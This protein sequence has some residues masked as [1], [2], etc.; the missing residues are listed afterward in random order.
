MT[1]RVREEGD[2]KRPKIEV[3][4]QPTL[5]QNFGCELVF[6]TSHAALYS[7]RRGRGRKHGAFAVHAASVA[8]PSPG[9]PSEIEKDCPQI[10]ARF[11][12][13]A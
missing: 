9:D 4:I 6:A 13:R 2:L 12:L 3:T 10:F 7:G 1:N 11:K 8:A 5:N